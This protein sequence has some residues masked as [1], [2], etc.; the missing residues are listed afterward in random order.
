M[1]EDSKDTSY[2]DTSPRYDNFPITEGDV[3]R[4]DIEWV[5]FA[6]NAHGG[7]QPRLYAP[8]NETAYAGEIDEENERIRLRPD[9][10]E[11]VA[12]GSLGEHIES[13]GDEHGWEWLSEFAQEYLE[14]DE[15]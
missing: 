2:G 15:E 13:I 8:H 1:P 6:A 10:A 4:S 3:E 7:G 12:E 5:G 11:E 14:A 9:S